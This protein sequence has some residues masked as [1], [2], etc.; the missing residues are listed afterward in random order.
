MCGLVAA[1]GQRD[2]APIL[3][4]GL[5]RLEYRGYDSAGLAVLDRSGHLTRQRVCGKV[6]QLIEHISEKEVLGALGIAHTRWATHG[7]PSEQNAHPHM[8]QDKVALVHNGI[9]ENYEDLKK[10]LKA[11]N[12]QLVSDSDSEV[13]V[14]L[15][16]LELEQGHD[17][18][19]AMQNTVV[20]L[21]GAFA[22]AV[23]SIDAPHKVVVARRNC[24]LIIGVGIGEH[25]IASD[26]LALL[27]T[28]QTFMSL[29]EG[30]VAEVFRDRVNIF[31][32]DQQP[33][34]REKREISMSLQTMERGHYR[35]FMQ[36]E[37]FEQ[38]QAVSACLGSRVGD[39]QILDNVFGV[40]ASEAFDRT[41]GIHI[42]A[43]GT[44]YHAGLVARYWIENHLGLACSVE[45]ASEYRYKQQVVP[46]G[47]LFVCLS[48]SGETADT[49]G[50]LKKAQ[51]QGYCGTLT[52]CNVPESSLV[53]ESMY[54]FL[55]HAGVEVGVASTKAF[56]TQLTG[57]L[58]LMVC[59]GRRNGLSQADQHKWVNA[60]RALPG[61]VKKILEVDKEIQKLAPRFQDKR[62]A[63]F[64][65]RGD[66]YPV[67]LEGALKL[68]E[69]SY[70][71]SQAYPAG[72]LKHGPLALVDND[73][74]VVAL[75]HKGELLDKLISN[76][77]EVK[78]RNG[79]LIIFSDVEN[80]FFD[81]PHVRVI[82]VPK[83][84][85]LLAPILL[86]IPLQLLAYHVAV[87]KGTDVDRP[88][89][90]AK[91]VTVE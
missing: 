51:S 71:H 26:S 42:V 9:I 61:R 82:R 33:V 30:D 46:K 66:L 6:H 22:L 12:Q 56:T 53:R 67:A 49:L 29:E 17:L 41:T 68:T 25:F 77:Q 20:K 63:L 86:T 4:E 65:G 87:L 74:L 76:L 47:T 8:Y 91:S 64:L 32:A 84:D 2:V 57:L 81:D 13:I 43:C 89:N 21:K 85:S 58:M 80:P 50:A 44:S 60:L 35:H 75:A 14:K 36:K 48:Q 7:K 18:L 27:G 69:I 28:T 62:H 90:L 59:I 40:G 70:I 78:A 1:V 11:Q 72:E 83:M 79:Q 73:M 5:R 54:A 34:T 37:I 52:I 15:I 24:P 10:T 31:D 39:G 16:G 19:Q 38:P 45:I 55:T 88:R 23:I 3:L